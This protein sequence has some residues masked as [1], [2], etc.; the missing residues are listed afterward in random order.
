LTE[1]CIRRNGFNIGTVA[2]PVKAYGTPYL[3][4]MHRSFWYN[5]VAPYLPVT[6]F[7]NR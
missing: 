3:R 2:G 5:P 4:M 1:H 6:D 7:K